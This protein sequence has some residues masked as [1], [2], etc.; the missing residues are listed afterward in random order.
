VASKGA[1]PVVLDLLTHDEARDLLAS[2][3]GRDR[4]AAEPA[5]TGDLIELCTRLPLALGIAAARAAIRVGLPLAETAAELRDAGRP[6]DGFDVGDAATSMRAVFSWSYRK[7]SSPARRM[8]RLLGVHPGPDISAAAAASMADLTIAEASRLL[9][10][11][12]GAHLVTENPK[13]RFAFHDLLRSYA[14]ELSGTADSA[15]DRQAATRRM[16]DHYLHS[17]DVAA[18]ALNPKPISEPVVLPAPCAGTV[19]ERPDRYDEAWAW[20][21]AER[22]VLLA[23]LQMA[24]ST[25][26]DSYALALPATMIA[27]FSRRGHWHEWVA[28]QQTALRAAQDQGNK[29]GEARAHSGI[30]RAY[31]WLGRYEE[32]SSYLGRALALF[33]ELGDRA[34]QA[35]IHVQLGGMLDRQNRPADA[36]PHGR[37]ALAHYRAIGNRLG[38]AAALNNVGWYHSLLGDHEQ[39]LAYCTEALGLFA[40]LGD[41]LGEAHALDSVGYACYHL[42]RQSE[43]AASCGQA[44]AL[45]RELRAGYAEGMIYIHL[46]DI[47]RAEGD[48]EGAREHWEQAVSILDQLGRADAADGRARLAELDAAAA[49]H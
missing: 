44:L 33:T 18:L 2:R 15:A 5:A 42:G 31:G 1:H 27:Y 47:C 40:E 21:E 11:L 39:A 16:L 13:G 17:A 34:G 43:A 7:L 26:W 25:G 6:L 8:F 38:Q 32:A 3:L 41:R 29:D 46:G 37:Q 36:L 20:F 9:G 24:A 10:E 30:G 4:V 45:A 14:A 19:P 28:T 49:G 23:T 35:A 22:P 12:T 48:S